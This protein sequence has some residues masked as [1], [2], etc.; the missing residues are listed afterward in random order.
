MADQSH[1]DIL[2]QG[3]E[4]WNSWRERNPSIQPD[5]SGADLNMVNLSGA[6]LLAANLI[7]ANLIGANLIGANLAQA[8]SSFA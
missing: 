1:L 7:G 2:Q 3:R 6:E 8:N 4:A 5:F